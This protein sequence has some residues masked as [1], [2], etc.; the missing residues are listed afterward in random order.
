MWWEENVAD[1]LSLGS[2]DVA[3]DTVYDIRELRLLLLEL[4]NVPSFPESFI[5]LLHTNHLQHKIH[6]VVS[7]IVNMGKP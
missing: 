7:N 3:V 1:A 5:T 4:V 2:V 6:L